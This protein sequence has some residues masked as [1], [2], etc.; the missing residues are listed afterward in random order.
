MDQTRDADVVV[1]GAGPGGLAAAAYLSVCGRRVVLVDARDVPGGHQSSF[2]RRGYELEIGLHYVT[3]EPSR[4]LLTPLGIP[5][6]FTDFD[7]DALFTLEFP[8]MTVRVPRGFAAA[9]D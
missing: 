3:P 8:E 5:V 4:R 1:V 7:P 2:R 6:V 9:R